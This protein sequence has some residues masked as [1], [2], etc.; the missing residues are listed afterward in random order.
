MPCLVNSN[1]SR[2]IKWRGFRDGGK[3]LQYP[4]V[5]IALHRRNINPPPSF[6]P[7]PFFLLPCPNKVT[8]NNKKSEWNFVLRL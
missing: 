4:L 8:S 7:P 3:A 1:M 5:Y 2:P 6:A